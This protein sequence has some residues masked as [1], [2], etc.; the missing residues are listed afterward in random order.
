MKL[1]I[2]DHPHVKGNVNAN[3]GVNFTVIIQ[4]A[5]NYQ[6]EV[7]DAVSDGKV[8]MLG[9]GR[10]RYATSELLLPFLVGGY[11]IGTCWVERVSP[12][13]NRLH[14]YVYRA[15]IPEPCMYAIYDFQ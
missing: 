13:R 9:K 3:K 4:A 2:F 15:R 6:A 10:Y 11:R 7:S 1:L 5:W 8:M 14:C 12:E